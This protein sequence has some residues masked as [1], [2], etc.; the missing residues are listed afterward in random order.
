[1]RHLKNMSKGD[2]FV[3]HCMKNLYKDAILEC[4]DNELLKNEMKEIHTQL[5]NLYKFV[6]LRKVKK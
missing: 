1:M 4:G 5:M 3:M 6:V 2:K